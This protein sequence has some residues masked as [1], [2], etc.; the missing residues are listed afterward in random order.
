MPEPTSKQK[1][2]ITIYV[3]VLVLVIGSLWIFFFKKELSKN[4]VNSSKVNMASSWSSL[5]SIFSEGKNAVNQ[6]QDNLDRLNENQELDDD[7]KTRLLEAVNKKLEDNKID[8]L[9]FLENDNL[10]LFYPSSWF[11]SEEAG[12]INLASYDLENNLLPDTR[13][14]LEIIKYSNSESL[15]K[16]EW[17]IN[18]ENNSL[19]YSVETL[20]ISS[21]ESL[22][23]VTDYPENNTQVNTYLVPLD[24]FM[25]VIRVDIVNSYLDDYYK[26]IIENII[27]SI[28][29]K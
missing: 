2:A 11:I 7:T 28:I 23:H 27:N 21:I 3:I 29:I 6:F 22:K 25:L 8:Q 1:L 16:E 4:L 17:L 18:L 12:I 19:A 10:K 15:S 20:T 26:I 5:T 13:A 14:G 9:S 24:N